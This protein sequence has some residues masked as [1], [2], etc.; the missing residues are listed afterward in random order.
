MPK[1]RIFFFFLEDFFLGF[2]RFFVFCLVFL[3]DF[4]LGFFFRIFF[5]E[6]FFLEDFF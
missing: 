4:F 1:T 6:F 2:F 3:E 5:L